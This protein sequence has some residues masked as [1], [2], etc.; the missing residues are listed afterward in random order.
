MEEVEVEVAAATL[1]ESAR[2]STTTTATTTA[3]TMAVEWHE[4]PTAKDMG[5]WIVDRGCVGMVWY[6]M[7]VCIA[8][9]TGSK[10]CVCAAYSRSTP[11]HVYRSDAMNYQLSAISGVHTMSG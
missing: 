7:V 6:G 2:P 5:E 3:T 8:S 9:P 10:G 1:V 4:G 11:N